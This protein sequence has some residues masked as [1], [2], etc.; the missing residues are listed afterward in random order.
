EVESVWVASQSGGALLVEPGIDVKGALDEG[1]LDPQH[2]QLRAGT[3]VFGASQRRLGSGGP[4]AW[5]GSAAR[6]PGSPVWTDAYAL[7]ASG[8]RGVSG[9]I[10]LRGGLGIIGVDVAISS[11]VTASLT[12]PNAPPL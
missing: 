1:L 12:Q 6:P 11:L 9:F 8:A 4:N 10:P 2:P 5:G 3:D 7:M